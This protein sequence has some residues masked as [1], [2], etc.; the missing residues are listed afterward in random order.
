MLGG[1]ESETPGG[2]GNAGRRA[3]VRGLLRRKE[4]L[5]RRAFMVA[6]ASPR[7]CRAPHGASGT[8]GAMKAKI[9]VGR[10]VIK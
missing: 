8:R 5:P 10:V 3:E 4:K 9:N 6:Q 2:R 1:G 7:G